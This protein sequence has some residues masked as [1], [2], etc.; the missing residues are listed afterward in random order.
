VDELLNRVVDE[1]ASEPRVMRLLL[2]ALRVTAGDVD[3]AVELVMLR[4]RRPRGEDRVT[5]DLIERAALLLG[6]AE[7]L[8]TARR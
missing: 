4:L 5:G 1:L 6:W 7:T 3:G 2:D 8:P